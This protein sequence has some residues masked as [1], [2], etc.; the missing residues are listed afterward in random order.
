MTDLE[1]FGF[2]LEHLGVDRDETE[3]ITKQNL[4]SWWPIDPIEIDLERYAGLAVFT[5]GT[6]FYFSKNGRYL[7]HSDFE[8]H[9]WDRQ[10]DK[11]MQ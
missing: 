9:W 7:G 3:T 5:G 1:F 6:C 11:A 8:G 10:Y 2:V 4:T